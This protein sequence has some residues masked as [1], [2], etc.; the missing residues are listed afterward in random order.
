MQYDKNNYLMN[1]ETKNNFI[2]INNPK[3]DVVPAVMPNKI[4]KEY[5]YITAAAIILIIIVNNK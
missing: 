5:V 4:K 2:N 1:T 3:N